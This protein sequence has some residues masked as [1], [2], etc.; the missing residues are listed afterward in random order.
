MI[1]EKIQLLTEYLKLTKS[2]IEMI[3]ADQIDGHIEAIQLREDLIEQIKL[4]D[5]ENGSIIINPL[6]QEL[7]YKIRSLDQLLLTKME[8]KKEELRFKMGSIQK[9]KQLRNQYNHQYE[10]ADGIFYDKRR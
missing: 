3:Y 4:L 6:I 9:G 7:L 8:E 5:D 1:E 10:N 2:A